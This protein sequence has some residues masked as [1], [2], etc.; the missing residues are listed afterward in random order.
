[1]SPATP[2]PPS[3]PATPRASMRPVDKPPSAAS[4]PPR[5]RAHAQA[6]ATTVPVL[7]AGQQVV[8][9]IDA[10]RAWGDAQQIDAAT[11][12]VV[13]AKDLVGDDSGKTQLAF[14]LMRYARELDPDVEHFVRW[15]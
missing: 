9:L 2:R 8:R 11:A 14:A 5:D 6:I 3:M 15:Q 13:V 1:M 7:S 12:L 10:V 4:R